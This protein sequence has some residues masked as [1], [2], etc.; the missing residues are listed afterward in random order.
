MLL[1]SGSKGYSYHYS[2]VVMMFLLQ[3]GWSPLCG[4][5]F[6]GH[7]AVVKTLIEAGA[8]VNQ[9]TKVCAFNQSLKF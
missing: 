3:N 4:A 7:C 2:L 9:I 1:M 6:N 5:S 8:N